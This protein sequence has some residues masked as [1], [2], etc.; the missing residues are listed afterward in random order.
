MTW[1]GDGGDLAV[2]HQ[3]SVVA[4]RYEGLDDH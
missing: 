1:A 4:A 2:D 3:A